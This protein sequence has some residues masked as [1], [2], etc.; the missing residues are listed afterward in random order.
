MDS[1]DLV[2]VRL[3][4][5]DVF[6]ALIFIPHNFLLLFLHFQRDLNAASVILIFL[7]LLA[8]SRLPSPGESTLSSVLLPGIQPPLRPTG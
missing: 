6:N 2:N 1:C 8:F 5:G 3:V 4:C 7:L